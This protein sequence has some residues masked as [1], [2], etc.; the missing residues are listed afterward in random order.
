MKL[1]LAR[2]MSGRNEVVECPEDMSGVPGVERFDEFLRVKGLLS[3][4]FALELGQVLKVPWQ[5][6]AELGDDGGLING[7]A[8]NNILE[9]LK[10][11]IPSC[12]ISFLQCQ[13]GEAGIR[14]DKE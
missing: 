2:L 7:D 6:I 5:K 13:C 8:K 1:L 12:T 9:Y 4:E 3:H 14:N 10:L 11:R